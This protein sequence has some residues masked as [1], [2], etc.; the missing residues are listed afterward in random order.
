MAKNELN[1]SPQKYA[2]SDEPLTP[3]TK[4][5][6]I[7]DSRIGSARMQAFNW[8]LAFFSAM[9]VV[10]V[11]AGGLIF[12]STKATVSPYVVEVGKDGTA[13][14][15]GLASAQKY[16]PKDE[17]IKY[18][19]TQFVFKTR[20]VPADSVMY[21]Q[22]W[23]MAYSFMEK[24]AA[25]KMNNLMAKDQQISLLEKR[26]TVL[27]SI[28]SVLQTTKDSWQIR[29]KEEIYDQNG[30]SK[31]SYAMTGLFTIS[32]QT[33]QNEKELLNNP[34]SI[35]IKDITWNRDF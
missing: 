16:V 11:L 23:L 30:N 21:K 35:Y 22:N 4:T 27:V 12:Q 19:L 20:S 10:L 8:R 26:H 5:K 25:N 15:V 13:A 34:L 1:D 33:P 3:Y 28:V 2:V 29:W 7:W 31:E 6:A 9:V 14:A 32:L 24:T 18:F 17:E